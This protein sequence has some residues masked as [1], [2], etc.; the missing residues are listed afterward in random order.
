MLS[1][2]AISAMTEFDRWL[3]S[4]PEKLL[5]TKQLAEMLGYKPDTLVQK[6]INGS[7]PPF[8]KMG[9]RAIRYRN[10]DVLAWIGAQGM[11]KSTAEAKHARDRSDVPD[12]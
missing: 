6:R 2:T 11:F 12:A 5:T 1:T 3:K 9:A 7:G 10:S 8:I 4:N